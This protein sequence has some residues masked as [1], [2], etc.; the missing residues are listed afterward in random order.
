MKVPDPF[1]IL[2]ANTDVINCVCFDESGTRIFYGDSSGILRAVSMDT[3]RG[4]QIG[5]PA[6]DGGIL[7]VAV[8]GDRVLRLI[9]GFSQTSIESRAHIWLLGSPPHTA[10]A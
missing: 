4:R 9:S 6:H 5:N 8:V 10:S 2:R 7:Q 1:Y 3:K